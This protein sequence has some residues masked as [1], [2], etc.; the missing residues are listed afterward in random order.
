[1]T[2]INEEETSED[3]IRDKFEEYG[4]IK[5]LHMNLDRRTGF[6]KGYVLMEYDT[7]KEAEAAIKNL[8]G[9]ELCGQTIHV[10]WTFVKGPNKKVKKSSRRGD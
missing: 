5:N 10:D 2:N 8:N 4:E 3:D 9:T 7:Y 1:M 6:A